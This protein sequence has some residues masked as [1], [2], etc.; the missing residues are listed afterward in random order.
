MEIG[1]IG[2]GKMGRAMAIRLMDRGHRVVVYDISSVVVASMVK[3]GLEGAK[4]YKTTV[5]KINS[6]RN[7]WLMIPAGK[8]VD[9]VI[10]DSLLPYLT[11]GDL[12]IDGGNSYY[13]DSVRRAN[14]LAK[15]KIGFVDV[16]TSGGIAGVNNGLSLMVGGSKDDFLRIEPILKDLAAENGYSLMGNNGA[17][18]FVKMV[19]N[20][21][22]YALLQSYAE[23]FELLKEGPFKLDLGAIAR[24]WNNG[25]IVRSWLLELTQAILEKNELNGIN[26]EVGGGQTGRWAAEAAL[27]SEVPFTMLGAALSE[28]YRSRRESFAAR[29]VAALR[30][31]FGG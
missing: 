4:D 6:P 29:L 3:R 20:G 9:D 17:G 24:V 14:K 12:L 21:I 18:H 13:K 15:R 11:E 7:I 28:R 30:L 2:L 5:E 31:R 8:I 16:G 23:G 10:F 19:H 25:S 22:E 26:A 1:F 27:E